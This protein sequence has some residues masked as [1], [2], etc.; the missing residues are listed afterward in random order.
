MDVVDLMLLSF[1]VTIKA[2]EKIL[3]EASDKP[4]TMEELIAVKMQKSGLSDF[5]CEYI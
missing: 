1:H 4:Q 5:S 2:K 3:V